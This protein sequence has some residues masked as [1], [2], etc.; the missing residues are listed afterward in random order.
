[1]R[2][3]VPYLRAWWGVQLQD[4]GWTPRQFAL[5]ASV[6]LLVGACVGVGVGLVLR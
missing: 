2:F 3:L 5:Y 6:A 4:V 1:V